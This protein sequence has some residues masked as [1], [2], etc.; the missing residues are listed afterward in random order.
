VPATISDEF[1]PVGV[2]HR[3]VER[4]NLPAQLLGEFL[5]LRLVDL[6]TI[7]LA[8]Q[9][10]QLLASLTGRPANLRERLVV[11]SC[12]MAAGG[13]VT[14]H[15]R[16]GDLRAGAEQV[17]P[18]VQHDRFGASDRGG[19]KPD[20]R[21]A[22]TEQLAG[23]PVE[24]LGACASRRNVNVLGRG[25]QISL[26]RQV[27]A[28][29]LRMTDM[30]ISPNNRSVLRR[31]CAHIDVLVRKDPRT[32]IRDSIVNQNPGSDRPSGNHLATAKEPLFIRSG[33]ILPD[34][35]PAVSI[36]AVT[37]TIVRT[38]KHSSIRYRRSEVHRRA[39]E[40]TPQ[41][42]STF[43]I[44]TVDLMIDSG[45]EIDAA[46]HNG[47]LRRIIESNAIMQLAPFHRFSISRSPRTAW[48]AGRLIRPV[49]LQRQ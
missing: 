7:P 43:R 22:L 24:R 5:V 27:F 48:T 32:E 41:L 20:L 30:I 15:R 47:H 37:V 21:H 35:L 25:E 10:T 42:R 49:Y 38:D 33:T 12:D 13:H 6:A 1:A 2:R 36:Q 34:Q 17:Q 45:S 29:S 8:K 39:G 4:L 16:A 31:D 23:L 46:T 3:V 11:H 28:S 44:Q 9:L 18:T 19:C 26:R 14:G 40:E